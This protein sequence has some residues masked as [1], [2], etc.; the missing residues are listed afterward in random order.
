MTP[1]PALPMLFE[2]P[3]K[4]LEIMTTSG[5]PSLRSL[6]DL[7][8]EFWAA[9]TE[10][11]RTN[12]LSTMS[13]ESCDAYLLSESS[14]FVSD[15]RMV[16]ITCGRTT[17]VDAAVALL[18]EIPISQIDS[19][20]YERKNE[21]FPD[22]QMT[23]FDEDVGELERLAPGFSIVFGDK[24]AD[25]IALWHLDRHFNPE[26][27]DTTLELLMYDFD[28][29]IREA[30]VKL[31]VRKVEW[32]VE[33]L[34]KFADNI[35]I[36]VDEPV[37]SAF[38]SSAYPGLMHDDVKT[39][40]NEIFDTIHNC[41][42]VAGSHCCGNT[43]WSLF[44]DSEVDLLNFDAYEFAGAVALYAQDI[45]AYLERGGWLAWGVVPTSDVIQSETAESIYA[46]LQENIAIFVSKGIDEKL[47]KERVVITPSC[48]LG[49]LVEDD[50]RRALSVLKEVGKMYKR[51]NA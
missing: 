3:E 13:N 16:M 21:N 32:Q 24:K 49:S 6:R 42:A 25:H 34:K 4:K 51:D 12:I 31:L 37:L 17:L 27:D 41:G 44:T 18:E 9:I 39:I 5:N 35:L 30:A 33:H 46:K 1:L 47:I 26:P 50:A 48:G 40:L 28:P 7:G 8:P 14:L 20:I 11:A 23:T 36:F 29:E 22:L 2:G 43:E 15:R 10:R 45:K 19:L 38:G